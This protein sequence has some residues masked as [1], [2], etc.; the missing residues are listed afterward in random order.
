[1]CEFH[2]LELYAYSLKTFIAEKFHAFGV[3]P[4]LSLFLIF[5]FRENKHKET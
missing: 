3:H 1:M 5:K 2:A 4:F